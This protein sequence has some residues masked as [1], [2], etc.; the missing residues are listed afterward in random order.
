MIRKILFWLHLSIGVAA[1]VFIF[2]TSATGVLLS[3]ER[4]IVDFVDRDI[5]FVSIPQDA[6][7]RPMNDL[8]LAVRRAGLGDPTGIVVRNQPQ[9]AAQFTIGRNKTVYVDPYSGAL[10]GLSSARAHDFFFTVERLHRALGAP[11]G[12]KNAARWVVGVANLLF[13]VLILFGIVLWVPRKWSANALRASIAFRTGLG[14]KA[15]DWNWHNVIG[16]WCALPLLV[17]V[18]TG[19]VM[20]FD[21]ANMLLFR[22]SGSTPAA[23]SL[24][25]AWRTITLNLPRGAQAPLTAVVDTGTG[26]QPQNRP[27]YLL[28][29]TTG[30]LIKKSAFADNSLG[31]RLRSFVRFGHTGEYGGLPGQLIAG[32]VSLGACVLVYTGL[33]L[34]I[35]RLGVRLKRRGNPQLA[36]VKAAQSV[37]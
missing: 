32:L 12:S 5:R 22:L 8:L 18:L 6:Q 21:W 19:V 17:I 26:G 11:L 13:G 20:S 14:G 15:R 9:A 37:A 34:A 4:Q 27:Q 31:Q 29:R 10:L 28:N 7:P 30:A 35:R 2:I 23:R 1:G 3:F 16:I 33:S 36:N 24:N 25:P